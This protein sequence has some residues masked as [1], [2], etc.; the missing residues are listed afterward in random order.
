MRERW[1]ALWLRVRTLAARRRLDR[2]LDAE[3]SFHL[4]MRADEARRAGA[5]T[6][7]A[8]ARAR[9]RFG[10]P[11]AERERSRDVW[12][13]AW[14]ESV[15]RDVRLSLRLLVR[16][17]GFA[18]VAIL[19]LAVGIGATSA[20]FS[21]VNGV[22][23]R[24]LPYPNAD[25]IMLIYERPPGG[26][27]NPISVLNFLDW[28]QT[29]TSF[30]SLTATTGE[31]MTL[32]GR[33]EPERLHVARVSPSYFDT[34]GIHPLFG[35]GFEAN[36]DQA[37]HDHV[38]VLQHKVWVSRFGADRG[39][40]G[41]TIVL[42]G[43]AF[44]VVGIMPEDSPFE[45]GF[46]QAWRPMAFTATERSRNSHW[47]QA[48]GRLKPGVTIEQAQA[49]MTG[50]GARIAAAYPESNKGWSVFV[51]PYG[52]R[53]VSSDLAQSLFVLFG[54]V[55]MLLLIGAV[56]L[57]NLTLARGL[58]RGR[59]VAVRAALGAGR[60]RLVRQ[61]VTENLVLALVGGIAG[62]ALGY[63]LMTVLK[64]AIPDGTLPRESVVVLD[65]RVVAFAFVLSLVTGVC[66]GL[67][68]AVQATKP[69][70]T[71]GMKVGARGGTSDRSRRRLRSV[72]VVTEIALAFIL[73]AGAG[74]LLRSF[75]TLSRLDAGFDDTNVVTMGLPRG[76]RPADP[77]HLVAFYDDVL[78]RVEAVP[79]VTSAGLTL[80]LPLNGWGFGLPMQVV[81][82]PIVDRAHRQG[83]GFKMVS[84]GYFETL[85]IRLIKGRTF[86]AADQPG[87]PPVMVVNKTLAD[88]VFPGQ[89]A[90]G[91]HLSVPFVA[92]DAP[93]L[94]AEVP[95]EIVGIIADENVAGLDQ[96]P[97]AGMYVPLA[98]NPFAPV[99]LVV[100]S[101]ADMGATLPAVRA[102]VHAL[103]PQQALT[104]VAPLATLR[105]DAT[106]QQRLQTGLLAA[107]AVLAL[108]LAAIGIYGVMSYSVAQRT[109]EIGIR[110]AL[111]A[112]GG[113][114]LGM[115][116][117]D[118]L[119]LAV[120]GL[121]LG[122]AGALALS[123]TLK[124]LLFGVTP[125]DPITLVL[126]VGVLGAMALAAC[127]IPARRAMRLDPLVALRSE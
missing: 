35:P 65:T 79:G 20:I 19:T 8:A 14:T 110:T 126:T 9:R 11:T 94:G 125:R 47:L 39:I 68:P 73:V 95:W 58:T 23:L 97:D 43:E 49:E 88:K 115:V 84:R 40:V 99:S 56:N 38:V 93:R 80:S 31:E 105:R 28:Q 86:T 15:I 71:A 2:D 113:S 75:D 109:R 112:S 100:R 53:V 5:S 44:T 42:D 70:L 12:T 13:F 10:N 107:F 106:A 50:I 122:L 127:L 83:V 33:S 17:P 61:F 121:V 22:I 52:G 63:V 102:A 120:V 85:R 117:R 24:P 74:L 124:A 119:G 77:Q 114:V 92:S 98:Q 87:A 3:I 118:G 21:F 46:S 96:P 91:Q 51:E 16:Q 66:F 34:Y 29:A 48:V 7:D 59:E 64:G 57:A 62:V 32:G 54:A 72:L 25:R 104:D 18:L 67:V 30:S 81:G 108:A 55:G 89:E 78:A 123:Q 116:L 103:D 111:G 101:S 60:R 41:R 1:H 76:S 69:D 90:I 36:S 45:R 37:G 82:R 4:D 27:R 26:L 6:A